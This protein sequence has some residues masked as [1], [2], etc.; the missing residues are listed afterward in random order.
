MTD[1]TQWFRGGLST[2]DFVIRFTSASGDRRRTCP[3]DGRV[4]TTGGP[5]EP[6][7]EDFPD[8]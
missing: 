7:A 6:A 4:T 1:R 5:M 3:S 2:E 8:G